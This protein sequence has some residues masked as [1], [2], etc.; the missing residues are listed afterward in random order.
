MWCPCAQA[1]RCKLQLRV[2]AETTSGENKVKVQVRGVC[3]HNLS[4][5]EFLCSV[6][7]FHMV[8][9]SESHC[10][11]ALGCRHTASRVIKTCH[12]GAM[13]VERC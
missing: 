9:S 12:A 1:E 3:S 7:R 5:L 10:S 4:G 6:V 2:M 8:E 11:Q 13:V